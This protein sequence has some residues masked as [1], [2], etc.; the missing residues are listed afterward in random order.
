MNSSGKTQEDQYRQKLERV[1]SGQEPDAKISRDVNSWALPVFRSTRDTES[2]QKNNT[3]KQQ[4]QK[5]K[6]GRR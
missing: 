2:C 6:E 1:F 5:V 4:Q 3:N